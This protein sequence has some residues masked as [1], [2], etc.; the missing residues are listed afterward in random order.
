MRDHSFPLQKAGELEAREELESN[1]FV[2]TTSQQHI[3]FLA[4]QSALFQ[5]YRHR[6]HGFLFVLLQ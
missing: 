2:F 6:V 4:P 1:F 5:I 3:F